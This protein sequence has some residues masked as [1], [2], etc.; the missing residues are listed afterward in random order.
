MQNYS[1]NYFSIKL[2]ISPI[3]IDRHY[4]RKKIMYGH[5]LYLI[6]HLYLIFIYC[7][8]LQYITAIYF[9]QKKIIN[10]NLWCEHLSRLM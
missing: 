8:L 7:F 10:K 1:S 4:T 3:H 2:T 5:S 6:I 9:R